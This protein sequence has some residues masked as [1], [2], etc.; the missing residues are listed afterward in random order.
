MR[1]YPTVCLT[2]VY[3]D[4]VLY[5]DG[6]FLSL[7]LFTWEIHS[8]MKKHGEKVGIVS[9][10]SRKIKRNNKRNSNKTI[11][12]RGKVYSS[13]LELRGENSGE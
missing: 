7:R 5:S 6:V 13:V 1:Q 2:I 3:H 9:A 10:L 4:G 8:Q 12:R 11:R